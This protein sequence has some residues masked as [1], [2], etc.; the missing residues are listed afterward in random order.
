M[1]KT[2]KLIT[3]ITVLAM[4]FTAVFMFTACDL[5][6][7]SNNQNGNQTNPIPH[8][9]V[10][11]FGFANETLNERIFFD[12]HN[13][14]SNFRLTAIRIGMP[15]L[16][17]DFTR[18]AY[19][20]SQTGRIE[21]DITN[22]GLTRGNQYTI[23][24]VALGDGINFLDS[25]IRSII[26]V[27]EIPEEPYAPLPQ[28]GNWILTIAPTCVA[29]GEETRTCQNNPQLIETRSVDP[30]PDNHSLGAWTQNIKPT[31][32]SYGEN[33]RICQHD[34][35]DYF[36][37]YQTERAHIEH[38]FVKVSSSQTHT[39]A[40]DYYGNLWAWGNAGLSIDTTVP[41]LVNTDG[42]I[43]D[44]K[45]RY[46]L[47]AE[48]FYPVSFVID[49]NGGLW[50]WGEGLF[51][52]DGV[53][54]R[55]TITTPFQINTNGRMNNANITKIV[56]TGWHPY[57]RVRF[58]IDEN[59]NLWGWGLNQGERNPVNLMVPGFLVGDGTGIPRHLPVQVNTNGRMDNARIEYVTA[60][61]SGRSFAID[62]FGN[63]WGWGSNMAMIVSPGNLIGGLGDGTATDRLAPVRINTNGRMNNARV[64]SI[65][66]GDGHHALAIDENSNLW[67]WGNVLG[68]GIIGSS[69][70]FQLNA[71]GRFGNA[72]I[73]QA[74][75]IG[76]LSVVI[77][78]HG[79]FWS[80]GM[81][82]LD[83]ISA[84]IR[85]SDARLVSVVRH[86]FNG[87]Q[88]LVTFFAID[89]YGNLWS[90][91]NNNAGLLGDGREPV[92]GNTPVLVNSD[93]RMNNAR[94]VSFVAI[95]NNVFAIDEYGN[96]WAWGQNGGRLGDG[97]TLMRSAPTLVRIPDFSD[98]EYAGNGMEERECQRCGHIEQRP[99]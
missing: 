74:T 4:T 99:V 62:E 24:I 94:V 79:N 89:Y 54:T 92:G 53:T 20:R 80:F 42:R 34:G 58:A 72:K 45:V 63:L 64:A 25:E 97:T 87:D 50:A 15:N 31:C 23:D 52:G 38:N 47:A 12:D 67:T 96:L 56:A 13:T 11:G 85:M 40:I 14:A 7:S 41:T 30:N 86:H 68:T 66:I 16:N 55:Q 5:L 27:K 69:V 88:S 17:R 29:Y 82:N 3:L 98:W 73:E 46:V 22:I 65:S 57:E 51:F 93:G 9:R 37:T 19:L 90:M 83:L 39:L 35:C 33:I 70:P 91:G 1:K 60:T 43:N 61:L 75:A 49:E 71:N 8:A 6:G 77:D 21:F 78:E 44:A 26:I 36:E 28:W 76:G 2:T 32:C 10:T 18:E 48:S 59:G 81:N 95:F 84:P